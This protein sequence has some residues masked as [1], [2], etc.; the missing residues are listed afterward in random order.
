[1]IHDEYKYQKVITA[2]AKPAGP[3]NLFATALN[4]FD[5]AAAVQAESVDPQKF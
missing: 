3:R 4:A 1:M 2:I 5:T